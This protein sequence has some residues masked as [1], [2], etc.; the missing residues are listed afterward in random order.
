MTGWNTYREW[1]NRRSWWFIAAL[2]TVATPAI[3]LMALRL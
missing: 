2:W 1:C 3:I